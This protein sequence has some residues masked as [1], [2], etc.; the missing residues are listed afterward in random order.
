[1]LNFDCLNRYLGHLPCNY[2]EQLSPKFVLSDFYV[3]IFSDARK[4]MAVCSEGVFCV[5]ATNLPFPKMFYLMVN[6]KCLKT[7]EITVVGNLY[8]GKS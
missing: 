6:A 8:E 4:L 5:T 2:T 3:P 7:V 1:M